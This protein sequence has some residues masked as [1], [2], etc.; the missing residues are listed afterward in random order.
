MFDNMPS[1]IGFA[2]SGSLRAIAVSGPTRSPAAPDLPTV[3]ESGYPDFEVMAWFGLF[4]PARTP[5]P[6]IDRLHKEVVAALSTPELQ[7][8]LTDL[9]AQPVGNTPNEFSKVV[10]ADLKRW[11]TV[12]KAAHIQAP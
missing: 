11:A 10:E 3:R 7:K 6:V 12:V 5:R 4:A 1:A 9:G 2:R 8:Q